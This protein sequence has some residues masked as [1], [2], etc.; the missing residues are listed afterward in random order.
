LTGS[1]VDLGLVTAATF[2]PILLGGPW[3]G[4]LVDRVDKRRL[5]IVTQSTAGVLALTLGLLTATVAPMR[6][7]I[8]GLWTMAIVGTVPITGPVA[9]CAGQHVGARDAL[10]LAGVAVLGTAALGWQS[11]S[12][13]AP[14]LVRSSVGPLMLSADEVDAG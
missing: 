12:D 9:G 14:L 7:R 2:L 3:A 11:L 4:V 10:G 13:R 6:G 1:G 8:M 5:M